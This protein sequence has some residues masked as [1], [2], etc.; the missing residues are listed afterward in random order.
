MKMRNTH[1]ALVL[2]LGC[3]VL[4]FCQKNTSKELTLDAVKNNENAASY[5]ENKMDSLQAITQITR[6]KTREVLELS[7]LYVNSN[8][9][10][11]I[12]NAVLRQIQ[13]YFY[14]PDSVTGQRLFRELD[15]LQ[16]KNVQLHN[17]GV[18]QQVS[19]KDTLHFADFEVEYFGK[20]KR[21]L[22]TFPR[23]AKYILMP[24]E[25]RFK[26][27]FKFYFMDFYPAAVPKDS[28]ASGVIK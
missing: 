20:G 26:K 19:G 28:V 23:S 7:I 12:D 4:T 2:L 8:K 22:G 1:R 15:S 5:P 21:S 3:L 16:V 10:T 13:G 6:Q 24:S 11:E 14:R 27:E 18:R 25:V 9:S 17:F